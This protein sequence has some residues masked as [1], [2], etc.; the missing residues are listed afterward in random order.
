M[1]QRN[2]GIKGPHLR[3]NAVP[4][5]NTWS[6]GD[7][8]D[9][10]VL[11]HF[12]AVRALMA[13]VVALQNHSRIGNRRQRCPNAGI[14]I[15]D[16]GDLF[17]AHPAELVAALIGPAEIHKGEIQSA[18]MPNRRVRDF[19]VAFGGIEVVHIV[20]VLHALWLVQIAELAPV[21]EGAGFQSLRRGDVE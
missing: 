21:D 4:F 10:H 13:A 15:L 17:V 3:L 18:N 16:R 6:A 2:A 20:Q 9:G 11:R 1:S 7:P 12:G 5:A 19:P 14:S 8:G